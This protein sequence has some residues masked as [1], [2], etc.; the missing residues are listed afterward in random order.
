MRP[1]TLVFVLCGLLVPLRLPAHTASR[2]LSEA[3]LA[4]LATLPVD[5]A[6]R[7]TYGIKDAEREN[8]HFVPKERNGL[9]LKEMTPLQREKAL[10][11]LRAGLSDRGHLQ[12][13]AIMA[14]ERVL[15]ELEGT[16]RRDA[17]LYTVTVFGTP[18]PDGIWGWRFEG[19]HLSVNFTLVGSTHVSTTPSFFGSNPAEVRS[20]PKKG[21]R[22]LG[23]LEDLG[24]DVLN[25]LDPSQRALAVTSDRAPND[26]LT[27]NQ[28]RVVLEAPQGVAYS[29]MSPAQ[30]ARLQALVHAYVQRHREDVAQVDLQKI[31]A[32]GWDRVHFSWAGGLEK[33]APHYY[34]VQ[35][36]TFVIE[37]DNVQN[38][39]N[40]VHAVWRDPEADFGRDLLKE[41]YAREHAAATR[42]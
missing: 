15:F 40:H 36:P 12:V 17:G 8:W 30:Q 35:G 20:G 4:F 33:G 22:A 37:Y 1:L 42:P 6:R 18:S 38:G 32:A 2:A 25:G 24:R 23:E 3:A 11:L 29:R 31:A 13:E 26:I 19:H 39:A 28:A 34:R 27:S 21:Q 41:H 5:L 7:T 16:A 10:A 9:A 14:L